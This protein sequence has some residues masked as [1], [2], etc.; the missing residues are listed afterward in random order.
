[1]TPALAEWIAIISLNSLLSAFAFYGR[2]TQ[3]RWRKIMRL[4]SEG[5]VCSVYRHFIREK[6]DLYNNHI[7]C[8]WCFHLQQFASNDSRS[9]SL[10]VLILVLHTMS[11]STLSIF[12]IF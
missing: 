6:A 10:K 9:L 8:N 2:V 12:A 7:F 5:T 4:K 3:R 11:C 1:M